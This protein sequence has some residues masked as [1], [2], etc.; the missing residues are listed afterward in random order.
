MFRRLERNEHEFAMR[1]FI[2]EQVSS[3]RLECTI[4]INLNNSKFIPDHQKINFITMST[5]QVMLNFPKSGDQQG[6]GDS[7]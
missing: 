4:L 2:K 5:S 1:P 7:F 3:I 6:G